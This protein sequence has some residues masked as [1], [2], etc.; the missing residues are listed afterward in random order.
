MG[1]ADPNKT[2]AGKQI[3]GQAS[4]AVDLTACEQIPPSLKITR[5]KTSSNKSVQGTIHKKNKAQINE[6]KLTQKLTLGRAMHGA[7]YCPKLSSFALLSQLKTA[8]KRFDQIG[9]QRSIQ[10][11]KLNDIVSPKQIPAFARNSKTTAY[12]HQIS[13][14]QH[15]QYTTTSHE[16]KQIPHVKPDLSLG[17]AQQKDAASR[18]D[19]SNERDHVLA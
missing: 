4:G 13:A 19:P 10:R 14:L 9:S 17:N 8:S 6:T 11:I 2:K 15:A 16:Q 3:R 18:P 7:T 12:R 1:N 5:P